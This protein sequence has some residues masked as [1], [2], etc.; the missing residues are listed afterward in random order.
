MPKTFFAILHHRK[1]IKKQPSVRRY[2]L[3]KVALSKDAAKIQLFFL[4]KTKTGPHHQ[5]PRPPGRLSLLCLGNNLHNKTQKE[6]TIPQG[7]TKEDVIARRKLIT[8]KLSRL[9]GKEFPCP[10]IGA[11]VIVAKK[12]VS[13]IAMWAAFT[14]LST[15]AAL[16]LPH[17]LKIASFFTAT[18]PKPKQK[19][20]Y[21]FIKMYIL[22]GKIEKRQLK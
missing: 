5:E 14:E 11:K 16:D 1:R 2:S 3:G 17:Q 19:A 21:N 15:K 4:T 8:G 6:M 12:S 22:H 9:V 7:N 18:D 10:C 13:E 20:N